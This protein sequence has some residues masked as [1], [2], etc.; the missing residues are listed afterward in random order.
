M[1]NNATLADYQ[2]TIM[3][4]EG[5]TGFLKQGDFDLSIYGS[6]IAEY[7]Y[8]KRNEIIHNDSQDY[9]SRKTT[10]ASL[11]HKVML[12]CAEGNVRVFARGL[13]PNIYGIDFVVEAF[14]GLVKHQLEQVET[15]NPSEAVASFIF[16]KDD[17]FVEDHIREAPLVSELTEIQQRTGKSIADI[18]LVES[19]T[20]L[21]KKTNFVPKLA[22]NKNSDAKT[23][24]DLASFSVFGDFFRIRKHREDHNRAS[25]NFGDPKTAA[26]LKEFHTALKELSTKIEI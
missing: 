2:K 17:K 4:L 14:I 18:Y 24:S 10:K 19:E 3:Q 8:Y 7:A 21:P 25:V 23:I 1:R 11:A 6:R 13:H 20:E 16:I 22:Q 9:I 26:H 12:D 15:S 5:A